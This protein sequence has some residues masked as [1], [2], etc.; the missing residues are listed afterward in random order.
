L[1]SVV[2]DLRAS[3]MNYRRNGANKYFTFHLKEYCLPDPYD[4]ASNGVAEG[5][6]A[7]AKT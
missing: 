7:S 1:R 3:D 4:L 6:S 2:T 5:I